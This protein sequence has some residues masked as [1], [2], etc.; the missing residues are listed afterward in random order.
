[1]TLI[2]VKLFRLAKYYHPKYQRDW[3]GSYPRGQLG[4]PRRKYDATLAAEALVIKNQIEHECHYTLLPPESNFSEVILEAEVKVS[5]EA[6][7][8]VAF[9]S[10]SR[11]GLM[12]TLSLTGTGMPSWT[13]SPT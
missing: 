2:L 5:A 7:I 6:N 13:S 3:R 4:G 10:I 12:V 8:D 9:M 1:M 11:V